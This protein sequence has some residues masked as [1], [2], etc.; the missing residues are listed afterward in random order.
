[1]DDADRQVTTSSGNV[2]VDLDLPS[3][4]EDML[5][6]VIAEAIT[7]TIQRRKLTQV[8]AAKIIGTDQAKISAL[9]RGRVTNF[10]VGRL[11][12]F[13]L[14]LGRDL[15]IHISKR[16]RRNEAGRIRIRECA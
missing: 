13:L 14:S 10:S 8:E 6:I 4:R 16:Y 2:F 15:D 12:A 5:K 3:S 11:M 7:T 9:L 1:M